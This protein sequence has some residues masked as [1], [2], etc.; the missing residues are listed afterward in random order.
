M[1]D[2]HDGSESTTERTFTKAEMAKIVN[3]QVKQKVMAA[4][5]EYGDLDE[6]RAKA[7]EADKQKSQIEKI[8]EQLQRQEERAAKAEQ[9]NTRRQVADKLGLTVAQVGRL[10]GDSLEEL[11]ADGAAYIEENG[12]KSKSETKDDDAEA[13]KAD[14]RTE[15]SKTE[16]DDDRPVRS[17]RPKEDLR[18]G[19]PATT[20][21]SD[22]DTDDPR[23]LAAKIARY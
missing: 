8:A 2:D 14:S 11:L 13:P 1:S 15:G 3:A 23:A 12:I 20:G 19:A 6:L 18:S 7:A 5:A 9:E 10:K 21:R 17:R 22:D 4:L 16:D